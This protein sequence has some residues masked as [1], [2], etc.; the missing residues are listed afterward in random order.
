LA[1]QNATP[2]IQHTAWTEPRVPRGT[3]VYAVGDIHGRLDLLEILHHAILEDA[4]TADGLKKILIHLGDYIDR[5]P[6]SFGV[7]ERLIR[8][9]L[10]G[11]VSINLKGNHEDFLL[12]FLKE[13]KMQSSLLDAWYMNGCA[14]TLLNYGIDIHG[15]TDWNLEADTIREKL[16]EAVPE[17]HK[18]FFKSLKLR[19]TIGDYLFVHAGINPEIPLSRQKNGDLLWIRDRF[20]NHPGPFGKIVVHGH[21]IF[22]RPEVHDHRIGI[23]TGAYYSNHLTCLV[24]EGEDRHFLET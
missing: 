3:R 14:E 7:V 8:A 9:P 17:S 13:K 19:H 6:D 10:E 21:T 5:G 24:L 12:R 16:A 18:K 20:L 15:R 23:D 1:Q 22:A 11:F 4:Q 2:S